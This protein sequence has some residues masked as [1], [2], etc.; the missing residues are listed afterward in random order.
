MENFQ[1]Y[2]NIKEYSNNISNENDININEYNENDIIKSFQYF[3]MNNN[4]KININDLKTILT[5]FGNK[6][7]E[8]EFDKIFKTFNY[9]LDNK[10]FVNYYELLNLFEN[11]K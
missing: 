1:K 5:S 2:S 7:S 9:S 6:M 10:D 3:D 8:E 11:N 4:G